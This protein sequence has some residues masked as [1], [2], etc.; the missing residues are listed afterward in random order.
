MIFTVTTDQFNLGIAFLIWSIH[1]ITGNKQYY[2]FKTGKTKDIPEDPLHN[3]TAHKMNPNS[4]GTLE[5]FRSILNMP[6][7]N[8]TIN[9]IK[10]IP[11][12]NSIIEYHEINR[13]LKQLSTEK[14][15]KVIN[16]TCQRLQHLIGFLRFD[17][18]HSNW[19]SDM[20]MVKSHCQRYWPRFFDNAQIFKDKLNTWH[21][22]REGIAFNIRP[23]D[24]W[25]HYENKDHDKMIYTYQVED[26]IRSGKSEMIKILDFLGLDYKKEDVDNWCK[27]HDIWKEN[28]E[29]HIEFCNDIDSIVKG[30]IKNRQMDLTK[31]KL[32]V[33]KEAVLLH[34]LMFKHDLNLNTNIDK[35]PLDTKEIYKLL[36]KNTRTGIEKLYD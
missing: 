24:F 27:I 18:E 19:Q 15:I 33:L 4:C 14:S 8:A 23:Y 11:K 26:M 5:S 20:E 21:D 30:I 9:H 7:T 2:D 31:Y 16:I 34:F 29:H 6:Q 1:N 13:R 36:G 22:I 35:L 3:G 10:F 12:A 17:T 25:T 32:D 28:L